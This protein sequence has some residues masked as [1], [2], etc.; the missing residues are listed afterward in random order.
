MD[1]DFKGVQDYNKKMG[2]K[3]NEAPLWKIEEVRGIDIKVEAL[4]AAVEIWKYEKGEYIMEEVVDTARIFESY[5]KE[6]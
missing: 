3:M 1:M 5:L 6:K 2:A 4:K